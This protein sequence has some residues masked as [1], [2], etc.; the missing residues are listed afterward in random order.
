MTRYFLLTFVIISSSHAQWSTDPANNLI[1][2]S[3]LNPKIAS[4][5]AGGCYITYTQQVG[6][7]D[8]IILQRL[9][10]YGYKPWGTSRQ[11]LGVLPGQTFAKITEDGRGGAI[12]SFVD[13]EVIS[14]KVPPIE[15]L[16][17]QRVDSSGNSLWGPTGVRV[18]LS[19]TNQGDQAIVSDGAGGCIVAWADTLGNLRVNRVDATANRVWG[20]SGMYLWNSPATPLMVSDGQQGCIL[21]LG[22]SRLQRI[23]HSGILLWGPSGIQLGNIGISQMI[24]DGSGGVLLAGMKFISSNNG[25]PLW[26]PK[27][28]RVDS[29]GAIL[30][31]TSGLTLEDSLHGLFLNPPSIAIERNNDGGGTFAWGKRVRPNVIRT[32]VQRVRGSGAF[33]FP[34][35]G[36]QVSA[37][38]SGGVG[39]WGIISSLQDSKIFINAD[40]RNSGT[41]R[42]Q[43][44]DSTGERLWRNSDVVLSSIQLGNVVSVTDGNGGVI[45]SGFVQSDFS[46]R[47]QQI[48]K[49]GNLGEVITST[50]S[51]DFGFP[52]RFVLHQNYP[53]PF[54]S[55]TII[56]YTVPT[57]SWINISV[58]SIL[59]QR[60]ITLVNSHHLPGSYFIYFQAD[61]FPSGAYFCRLQAQG[62][63]A[64]EGILTRKL[65]VVK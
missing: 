42:A 15:R 44:L 19:E 24:S 1:V 64:Q 56:S 48:G 59:G 46:I 45:V 11:I 21:F 4:D 35:S 34:D 29:I 9:N 30:W 13:V 31:D 8:R 62:Q 60:L 25:D 53:N 38:D 61:R 28:Q 43:R 49:N 22:A 57:S 12:V 51:S 14:P 2:G 50:M 6:I 55:S 33:V 27:A 32:F 7:Y 16:R 20:D 52:Q 5:S 10:R 39:T 54:N 26:T 18:S 36:I 47:A 3:G 65:L 41:T 40:A 58:Y 37:I 63:I 23:N 17:V